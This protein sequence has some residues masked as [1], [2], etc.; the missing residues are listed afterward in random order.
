MN[1]PKPGDKVLL[2]SASPELLSGLPVEDQSA[3]REAVGKLVLLL[4][5]D[6]DGR[7]E[8]EFTDSNGVM[9]F[10]YVKPTEIGSAG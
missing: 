7:A 5:W 2:L 1:R 9:H 10:I 3:I 6:G 4:E 8:L